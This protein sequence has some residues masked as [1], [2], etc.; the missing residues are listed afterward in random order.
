M[1]LTPVPERKCNNMYNLASHWENL[2]ASCIVET[3][4]SD[5]IIKACRLAD[6]EAEL[7]LRLID[8][9]GDEELSVDGLKYD[10]EL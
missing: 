8:L 7:S 3:L 2:T 5:G 10:K 9:P 6:P 4:Q 1:I